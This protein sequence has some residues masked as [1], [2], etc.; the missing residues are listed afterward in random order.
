[1][2]YTIHVKDVSYGVIE[3]EAENEDQAKDSLISNMLWVTRF[4]KAANTSWKSKKDSHLHEQVTRDDR[5]MRMLRRIR[6]G[7]QN[8][9]SSLCL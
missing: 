5:Q 1:M 4:G 3:V 6:T 8:G 2:K 7:G 9:L